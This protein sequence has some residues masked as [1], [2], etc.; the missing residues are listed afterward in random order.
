MAYRVPGPEPTAT[1]RGPTIQ[2][3]RGKMNL[4]S[5]YKPPFGS[6]AASRIR[7]ARRLCAHAS[8]QVCFFQEPEASYTYVR[9]GATTHILAAAD[10]HVRDGGERS[11]VFLDTDRG[12][13]L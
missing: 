8:R 9:F 13:R 5:P 12:P 3:R 10:S 6:P 7:E 11:Y 2:H 1:L 4:P